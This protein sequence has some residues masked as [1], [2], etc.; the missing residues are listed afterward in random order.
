MGR[1]ITELAGN[2][3]AAEIVAG[4]DA[5]GEQYAEYPV[6]QSLQ[7]VKEDVDAVIDFSNAAAVDALLDWCAEHKVPAA[8]CTTGLSGEQMEKLKKTSEQ[9]AVLKSANMSIGI[10]L[11]LRSE[12]CG[13]RL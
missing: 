11:L 7:D 13:S 1:M 12:A 2:D 4:V 6:Y 9:V 3:E 5:R 10:N 8:V